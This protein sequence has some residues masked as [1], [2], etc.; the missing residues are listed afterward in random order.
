MCLFMGIPKPQ[1]VPGEFRSRGWRYASRQSVDLKFKFQ[2]FLF[3]SI[4]GNVTLCRKSVFSLLQS[5]FFSKR[6][7]CL[8]QLPN[9]EGGNWLENTERLTTL[10]SHFMSAP[11]TTEV[12]MKSKSS[13][14]SLRIQSVI[15]NMLGLEK[16]EKKVKHHGSVSTRRALPLW[17]QVLVLFFF[18]QDAVFFL[19]CL[20]EGLTGS[21]LAEELHS[22]FSC[23]CD[24]SF[25]GL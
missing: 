11:G 18:L 22:L 17:H 6:C 2:P 21:V 8:L 10:L 16:W 5:P 24:I 23:F 19:A 20:S 13:C 3:H 7:Y 1:F 12:G 4:V 25:F 15:S 14:R 9:S